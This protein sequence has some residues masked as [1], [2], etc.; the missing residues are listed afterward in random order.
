MSQ[1]EVMRGSPCGGPCGAHGEVGCGSARWASR[2]PANRRRTSMTVMEPARPFL[3]SGGPPSPPHAR[4]REGPWG[5]GAERRARR[6][7]AAP[8]ER[9]W[10]RRSSACAMWRR[11]GSPGCAGRNWP[12][13]PASAWTTTRVSNRAGPSA[14]GLRPRR[15]GERPATR[16]GGTQLPQRGG[17]P[18][19]RWA[20]PWS[21]CR[22]EGA[23]RGPRVLARLEGTPA[24]VLGRRTDILVTN[25]MARALLHDFDAMPVR[26]RNAARWMVLDEAAR[27][28]FADGWERVA[29]EFVARCDGCGPPSRRHPH[30]RAGGRAVHEERSLP[31]L[32]GRTEGDAV[33]PSHQ[34]APP[35]G[36]GPSHPPHRNTGLPRRPG[37]DPAH[38]PLP[39]PAHPPTRP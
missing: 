12:R 8:G 39:T 37:P 11:D 22:A 26:N 5:H 15:P 38:V 7:P 30:R 32:V 14:L 10:I 23:S 34:A 36:G 29:S 31:P 19:S 35:P 6:V 28:L 24:L 18:A 20:P 2:I 16:P 1:V 21:P 3:G 9:R 25:R 13:W 33:Q 17:A 4:R 27:S